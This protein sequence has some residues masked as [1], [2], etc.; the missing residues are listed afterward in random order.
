[1]TLNT[2]FYLDIFGSIFSFICTLFYINAHKHAWPIGLIAV[3]INGAL[4]FQLGIYGDM[5][6]QGF[7]FIST[8]YG[9]YLWSKGGGNHKKLNIS[10]ISSLLFAKLLII[11]IV[12][13][14]TLTFIL[15]HF[16]HSQVPFWDAATTILSLIAQYLI[17]RKII[18]CWHL[19]FIIDVIY[20]GLYI[21][22]G[23]PAHSILLVIYCGMAIIGYFRWNY[24][25]KETN[26]Y[27]YLMD[28]TLPTTRIMNIGDFPQKIN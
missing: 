19:W 25:M 21:Y 16:T 27:E 8:F 17:C 11:A 10:N 2:L 7:Y 1:M 9:W 20:V 23:I 3:C 15:N 12:G 24:L 28:S 13:I 6:L 26:K 5:A 22:K 14:G 18:Q 4:Y